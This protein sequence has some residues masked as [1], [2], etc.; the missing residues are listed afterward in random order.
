M[1]RF[2]RT[3]QGQFL[4]DNIY[5]PPWE[6]AQQVIATQ[7]QRVDDVLSETK[8]LD[9]SLD[10]IRHLNFEAENQRV[11][12][13][14]N[15]YTQKIDELSQKIASDPLNYTKYMQEVEGL[16]NTMVKD[17]TSGDLFQIEQ[18]YDQF[19][20][21]MSDN[22]DLK[23]SDPTLY[24]QLANHWYKDVTSRATDDVQAKFQGV[25]GIAR[26]DIQSKFNDTFLKLK[27]D[28]VATTDGKYIYNNEELTEDR[29]AGMAWNMLRSDPNYSGYLNQMGN[30]LGLKGYLEPEAIQGFLMV[31]QKGE[32]IDAEAYRKLTDEQKK[33]VRSIV[34]P[35]NP[36]A[37]D[38]NLAT[39]YAY[40]QTE[41]KENRYGL[42]QQ[43]AGFDYK[44]QY[45]IQLLKNAAARDQLKLGYR[46]KFDLAKAKGEIEVMENVIIATSPK[47]VASISELEVLGDEFF[48]LDTKLGVG[49]ALS[50]NEEVRYNR[51]KQMFGNVTKK[52]GDDIIS[53]FG[54]DP[55]DYTTPEAKQARVTAIIGEINKVRKDPEY[56]VTRYDLGTPQGNPGQGQ[57]YG[58]QTDFTYR[59]QIEDAMGFLEETY[60]DF[61]KMMAESMVINQGFMPV[62]TN[63]ELGK[64]GLT[65]IDQILDRGITPSIHNIGFDVWDMEGNVRGEERVDIDVSP[66]IFGKANQ[67]QTDDPLRAI[68]N[69]LGLKTATELH[70]GDYGEFRWRISRG[71]TLVDFVPN[72]QKLAAEGIDMNDAYNNGQGFTMRYANLQNDF[73]KNEDLSNP[74]IMNMFLEADDVLGIAAQKVNQNIN[75]LEASG[76]EEVLPFQMPGV[77]EDWYK[78][79]ITP[80]G[81]YRLM[82][83]SDNDTWV[84]ENGDY[85]KGERPLITKDKRVL[86]MHLRNKSINN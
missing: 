43:K 85:G 5:Q 14:Q 3:A 34:N 62:G 26:P 23:N 75:T 36:F 24:N 59:N 78:V 52:Y 60:G 56:G 21:W 25:Q 86:W 7:E 18:R 33:G 10:T 22:E 2:Y 63:S 20:K 73:F 16:R 82:R 35:N 15:Q 8:I 74:E 38:I 12:D 6:L 42:Q 83:S 80:N 72:A 17:R 4:D 54:E 70:E 68:M 57:V 1:S 79:E 50:G 46:L 30:T 13:Y 40:Q 48:N 28:A 41:L 19:Q 45:D 55:A 31:N 29:L 67:G 27:A 69:H 11:Q 44:R 77:N 58:E 51:L 71:Q 32:I 53:A 66:N 81:A 84:Q 65:M 47:Q 64:K 37:S 76:G 61:S 39:G 49:E 9:D